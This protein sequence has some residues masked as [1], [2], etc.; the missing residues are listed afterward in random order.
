MKAM[1]LPAPQREFRFH[2]ERRWRFDFAWPD[3]KVAM[4]VEG[5]VWS[6]GRHTRGAGFEGDCEKYNIAVL[7]GWK[8]LRVTARHIKSGAALEWLESSL[9]SALPGCA[10]PV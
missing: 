5:G 4:E 6:G 2:P 1:R 7:A 3:R 10:P 9:T 8:V